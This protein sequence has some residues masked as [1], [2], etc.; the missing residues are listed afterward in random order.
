VKSLSREILIVPEADANR[1]T[2]CRTHRAASPNLQSWNIA[3]SSETWR[4][5]ESQAGSETMARYQ[6]DI[7]VIWEGQS[8]SLTGVCAIKQKIRKVY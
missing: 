7:M 8:I 5:D 2:E 4:A 1:L 3:E 6:T